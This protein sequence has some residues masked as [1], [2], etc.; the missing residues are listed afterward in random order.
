V[1]AGVVVNGRLGDGKRMLLSHQMMTAAVLTDYAGGIESPQ[2]VDGRED[3]HSDGRRRS[4]LYP[5]SRRS[6][7]STPTFIRVPTFFPLTS[8]L[9]VASAGPQC[10]TQTTVVQEAALTPSSAFAWLLYS[11]S[12]S[13]APLVPPSPS[14][15]NAPD[16]SLS[17]S[18][19]LSLSPAFSFLFPARFPY[20]GDFI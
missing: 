13:P 20:R 9:P 11:L 17:P 19:Y 5:P 18:G 6:C 4:A 3:L 7:F 2:V 15:Q 1:H 16:G 10:P 12:G 14:S 8:R